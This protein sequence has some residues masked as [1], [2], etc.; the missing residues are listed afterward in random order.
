M[1]KKSLVL[2]LFMAVSA[3]QAQY[4]LRY[5]FQV[6][7]S[8]TIEQTATQHMD[9]EIEGSVNKNTNSIKSIYHFKVDSVFADRYVLTTEFETM[10]FKSESDTFGVFMDIDT[11]RDTTGMS[12]DQLMMH[13]IFSSL[14]HKPIRINL[15]KTG[16]VLGIEGTGAMID[17]MLDEVGIEDE[18][19]RDMIKKQMEKDFGD[20]SLG[21]S[22]EQLFYLYPEHS[23]S[24]ETTWENTYTGSLKANNTWSLREYGPEVFSI[25]GNA[26]V[27]LDE[28][29]G[30]TG[31]QLTMKGHQETQATIET[32]NGFIKEVVINQE[33]EGVT[34]VQGMNIPTTMKAIITFKRL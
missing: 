1:F 14:L 12:Q 3:I 19:S 4:D 26:D 32:A 13:S 21:E 5:S 31:V 28:Q 20:K 33:T 24:I 15:Y 29:D 30:D 34:K 25:L 6:G 9:Q 22:M 7:D 2:L 11:E 8:F 16:K 10:Q 27:V 18:F 17:G 23:I